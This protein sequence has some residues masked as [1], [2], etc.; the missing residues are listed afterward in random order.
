[1]SSEHTLLELKK[2]SLT[3]DSRGKQ[4]KKH[5][6]KASSPERVRGIVE[7]ETVQTEVCSD[8]EKELRAIEVL[9]PLFVTQKEG[10]ISRR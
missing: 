9:K 6:R 3:E 2:T 5:S 10:T 8:V 4:S 1:M 7:G